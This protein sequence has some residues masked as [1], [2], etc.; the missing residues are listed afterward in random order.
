V[1]GVSGVKGAEKEKGEEVVNI[2]QARLEGGTGVIYT[3]EK[4]ITKSIILVVKSFLITKKETIIIEIEIA[5]TIDTLKKQIFTQIGEQIS[6][7]YNVRLFACNP[8]M[9][10][11]NVP[12]KTITQCQIKDN[13]KLILTAD[14]AFT[15]RPIVPPKNSKYKVTLTNNTLVSSKIVEE[16]KP[17][18]KPIPLPPPTVTSENKVEEKKEDKP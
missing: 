8:T 10:E 5:K 18:E 4:N 13:A 17:E 15:F 2:V 6:H 3:S 14:Y 12:S 11:L 9:T 7:Y 16:K 1:N